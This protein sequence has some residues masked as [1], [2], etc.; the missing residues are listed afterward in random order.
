MNIQDW[1]NRLNENCENKN[2]QYG[3]KWTYKDL[4]PAYC[5]ENNLKN[6][7]YWAY[8]TFE[9]CENCR[10]TRQEYI[11]TLYNTQECIYKY[12]IRLENIE[13]FLSEKYPDFNVNL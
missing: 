4:D 10:E 12:K 3:E 1:V 7:C 5:N 6:Y 8:K 11:Y 13:K 9:L 2:R